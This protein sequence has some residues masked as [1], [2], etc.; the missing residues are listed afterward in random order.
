MRRVYGTKHP[1]YCTQEP[2]QCAR[3][4]GCVGIV[5][6]C[7]V[8]CMVLPCVCCYIVGLVHVGCADLC[9]WCVS[10]VL[11][12]GMC[13]VCV[14]YCKD[15]VLIFASLHCMMLLMVIVGNTAVSM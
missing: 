9:S 13:V 11:V 1:F 8:L 4:T 12:C 7:G 6:L 10:A 14:W 15:A 3:G 2:G 5:V